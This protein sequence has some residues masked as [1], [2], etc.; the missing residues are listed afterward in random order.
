[1]IYKLFRSK[2]TIRPSSNIEIANPTE[3]SN[4]NDSIIY[5]LNVKGGEGTQDSPNLLGIP[6]I[7]S[8][9]VI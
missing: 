2:A 9:L 7:L 4:K 6:Y 1:M 8:V 3:L 5:N